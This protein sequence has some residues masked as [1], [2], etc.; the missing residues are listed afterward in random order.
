MFQWYKVL[1]AVAV[2]LQPVLM[3]WFIHNYDVLGSIFYLLL[4]AMLSTGAIRWINTHYS[5]HY[6]DGIAHKLWISNLD[7]CYL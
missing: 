3:I 1:L 6:W 4:S 5:C 2:M 7:Y